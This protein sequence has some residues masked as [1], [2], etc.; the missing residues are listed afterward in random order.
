MRWS[1]RLIRRVTAAILFC[2]A[3]FWLMMP[4]TSTAEQGRQPVATPSAA[5]SSKSTPPPPATQGRSPIV[6]PSSKTTP[7]PRA[8]ATPGLFA[9]PTA[10]P[11]ASPQGSPALTKTAPEFLVIIDPSHGGDDKGVIY[12]S[13]L[14]EKEITLAFARE[15]RDELDDRGIAVRLLR[16]SDVS[17]TIEK[18]A[19]ITNSHHNTV[20]VAIHAA[21]AGQGVR[22]YSAM[23]PAPSPH[24]GPFIPWQTAQSGALVRSRILA[25]AVVG[26]LQRKKMQVLGLN[27]PLRPLN[28]IVAPAIA[29]ELPPNGGEPRPSEAA[30]LQN[31]IAAAVAAG[32]A[33]SRN[34]MGVHP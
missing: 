13:K 5:P 22:I 34:Q 21:R 30:K 18:R 10:Q 24:S 16:E 1:K 32:I 17:L 15:L 14:Q 29:V 23:I 28:N 11:Q 27:A 25:K 8:T 33:T 20:Y 6:T 12:S 2:P 3:A 4:W 7:L 19:E 31:A 26:E 9:S